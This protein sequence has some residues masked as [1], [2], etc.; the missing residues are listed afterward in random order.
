MRRHVLLHSWK[1]HKFPW[2]VAGKLARTH[3]HTHTIILCEGTHSSVSRWAPR[4]WAL[5]VSKRWATHCFCVKMGTRQSMTREVRTSSRPC[6][7]R[8]RATMVLGME[9]RASPKG[10]T[11]TCTRW[12]Q[13]WVLMLRHSYGVGAKL[14]Q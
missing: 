8:H 13:N 7:L 2:Q 9:I 4:R 6:V 3:T 1:K 10:S 14:S 5:P 11:P 12:G